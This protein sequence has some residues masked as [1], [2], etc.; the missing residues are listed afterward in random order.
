MWYREMNSYD[1]NK[2][3][4]APTAGHFTQLIWKASKEMGSGVARK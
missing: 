3:Q 2:A 1:F 4:F